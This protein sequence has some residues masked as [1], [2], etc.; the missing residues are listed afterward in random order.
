MAHSEL[1]SRI[2]ARPDVFGG[3]PIVRDMRI[4][5]E[6]VLSLLAHGMT[7]DAIVG[8]YPGLELDDRPRVPRLCTRGHCERFA[9]RC[10][11]CGA[12]RFLV[13]RCVGR[14]VAEWQAW[15]GPRSGRSPRDGR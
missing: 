13:D 15:R 11:D 14:P 4:S 2:T 7:P 5:V 12:V 10:F 6:R 8:D 9:L 1:L 3:K